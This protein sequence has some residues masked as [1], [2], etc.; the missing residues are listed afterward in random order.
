MVDE[1]CNVLDGNNI[2]CFRKYHNW[3]WT[4]ICNYYIIL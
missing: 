4:N 2:E 3:Y 1:H